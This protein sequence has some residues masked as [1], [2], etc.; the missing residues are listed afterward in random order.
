M[1]PPD[2][3]YTYKL[4]SLYLGLSISYGGIL[5]RMTILSFAIINLYFQR[6]RR[7][8]LIPIILL[9]IRLLIAVLRTS[10]FLFCFIYQS[11]CLLATGTGTCNEVL[12]AKKN[13]SC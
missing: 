10:I 1:D 13:L 6:C 4:P 8:L 3:N 12:V 11:C 7:H 9:T 2:C 5:R